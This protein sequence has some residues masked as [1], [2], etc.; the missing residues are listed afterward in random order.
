MPKSKMIPLTMSERQQLND[1]LKMLD[2]SIASMVAAN[3]D[4]HVTANTFIG[5]TQKVSIMDA[6]G[7][8]NGEEL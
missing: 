1:E 5:D 7:L 6:L 3:R 4:T 8:Y 2:E